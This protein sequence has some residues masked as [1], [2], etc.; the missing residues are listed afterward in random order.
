LVEAFAAV[1]E[2][3]RRSSPG[4][5]QFE[6]DVCDFGHR[7]SVRLPDQCRVVLPGSRT[8]SMEPR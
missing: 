1:Q 5:E 2:Q 4:F 6:I 8:I 7:Q 3:N